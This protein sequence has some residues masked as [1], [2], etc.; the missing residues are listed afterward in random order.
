MNGKQLAQEF[1]KVR[2]Q[3]AT[4]YMSG[5]SEREWGEAGTPERTA[6]ILPKPF[7]N[8]VLLDKVHQVLAARNLAGSGLCY[9]L[10]L[11]GM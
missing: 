8:R 3:A 2:P 6:V 11:G 4:I 10:P 7:R 5:F 1:T 9:Q